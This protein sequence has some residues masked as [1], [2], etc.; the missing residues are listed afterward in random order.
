MSVRVNERSEI[1]L[2]YQVDIECGKI[3]GFNKE[4]FKSDSAGLSGKFDLILRKHRRTRSKQQ[5]RVQWW[6]FGEI[7]RISGYTP[8]QIKSACEK[9]FLE[10]EGVNEETAE[11]F[12]YYLSTSELTP[13]EHNNFMQE[14]RDWAKSFWELELKLPTKEY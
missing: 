3:L 11:V 10:R 4:L 2:V 7:A 14:V 8:Q 12:V 1:E 5:N 13:E 6:Y 9:K